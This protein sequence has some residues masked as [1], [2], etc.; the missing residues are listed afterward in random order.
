VTFTR[1]KDPLPRNPPEADITM[2]KLVI[3]LRSKLR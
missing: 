2:R 1:V 3:S